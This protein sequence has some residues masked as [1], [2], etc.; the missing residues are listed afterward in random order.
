MT[1]E[2]KKQ[3]NDH[4]NNIFPYAI[5]KNV[6]LVVLFIFV[7]LFVFAVLVVLVNLFFLLSVLSLLLSDSHY[8]L[9]RKNIA[10]NG[11]KMFTVSPRRCPGGREG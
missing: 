4:K 3:K 8:S 7:V 11:K 10:C 2:Q 6:V 9:Q 1:Q 5:G